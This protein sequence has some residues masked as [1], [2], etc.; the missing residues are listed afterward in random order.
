MRY[1]SW[2]IAAWRKTNA[3][4]LVYISP[5]IKNI[6]VS[7]RTE[8]VQNFQQKQNAKYKNFQHPKCKNKIMLFNVRGKKLLANTRYYKV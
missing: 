4:Y 5:K 3:L 7:K 2:Y 8:D 6:S 1:V